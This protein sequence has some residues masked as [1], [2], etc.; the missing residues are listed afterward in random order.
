MAVPQRLAQISSLQSKLKWIRLQIC[1]CKIASLWAYAHI[2]EMYEGSRS[3][4]LHYT[5][6]LSNPCEQ[7]EHFYARSL[8]I[9][10][11]T[12][13]DDFHCAQMTMYDAAPCI[14]TEH[15]R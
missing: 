15:E 1:Q 14:H 4:P 2:S 5:S 7:H 11:Q 12:V 10:Q 8:C 6:T 9:L 3:L 13:H